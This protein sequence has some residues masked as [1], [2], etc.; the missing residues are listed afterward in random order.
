MMLP[1]LMAYACQSI[2]HQV[3]RRSLRSSHILISRNFA[4]HPVEALLDN[5]FM[6]MSLN[7]LLGSNYPCLPFFMRALSGESGYRQ[8]WSLIGDL[9][10]SRVLF[11]RLFGGGVFRTHDIK[12]F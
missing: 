12:F 9:E 2:G 3:R 6:D 11:L 4:Q 10:I 1:G 7:V 8:L 5:V